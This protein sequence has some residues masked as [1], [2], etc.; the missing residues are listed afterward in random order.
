MKV[1]RYHT[2]YLGSFR[3]K[4]VIL[5]HLWNYIYKATFSRSFWTN[6]YERCSRWHII[7]TQFHATHLFNPWS[8]SV[9]VKSQN[10]FSSRSKWSL[11]ITSFKNLRSLKLKLDTIIINTIPKCKKYHI[12][13]S[14]W[15]SCNS[16]NSNLNTKEIFIKQTCACTKAQL[17]KWD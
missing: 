17:Y 15:L 11:A 6:Q 4:L 8:R 12:I 2:W 3:C 14:N 13:L 7:V 16:D 9:A 1:L 5:K 10:L